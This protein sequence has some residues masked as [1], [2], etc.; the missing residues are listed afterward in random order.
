LEFHGQHD[1]RFNRLYISK[2]KTFFKHKFK[3]RKKQYG[4]LNRID[5]YYEFQT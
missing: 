4:P 5:V 3:I 1:K 2:Q